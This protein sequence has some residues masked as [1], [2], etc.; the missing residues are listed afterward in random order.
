MAMIIGQHHCSTLNHFLS[1]WAANVLIWM[2]VIKLSKQTLLAP[3]IEQVATSS[4]YGQC[5]MVAISVSE[6]PGQIKTSTA[7]SLRQG[8]QQPAR[9]SEPLAALNHRSMAT[10]SGASGTLTWMASGDHAVA[11]S[12]LARPSSSSSSLQSLQKPPIARNANGAASI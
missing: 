7:Q 10:I 6:S 5:N 2:F 8:L 4:A 1:L 11:S 3:N 9:C 12:S